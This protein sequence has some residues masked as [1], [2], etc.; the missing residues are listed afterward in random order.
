VLLLGRQHSTLSLRFSPVAPSE[1]GNAGIYQP[2]LSHATNNGP[3]SPLVRW[4]MLSQ[5]LRWSTGA[6]LHSS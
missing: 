3:F 5:A 1:Q 6:V 2:F 4:R